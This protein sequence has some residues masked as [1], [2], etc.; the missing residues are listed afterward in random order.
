MTLRDLRFLLL[1]TV[2]G[3][4][5]TGILFY[6]HPAHKAHFAVSS[7]PAEAITPTSSQSNG[8]VYLYGAVHKQGAVT[9]R[10]G[11]ALTV[12][13]AIILDGGLLDFGDERRVKLLRKMP[14]GTSQ[15]TLVDLKACD[16]GQAKDPLVQAN[17]LINVSERTSSF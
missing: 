3:I 8:L 11:E 4:L 10:P 9:I 16:D 12:E 2:A 7:P 5:L 6:L 1:G 15:I 17:D 13:Q 14:N